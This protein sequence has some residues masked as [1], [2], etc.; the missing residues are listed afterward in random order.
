MEKTRNENGSAD[1]AVKKTAA[2]FGISPQTEREM[3]AFFM[4]TSVPRRIA[5][6]EQ[7]K[8]KPE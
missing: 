7:N 3:V 1:K 5:E 2:D 4:R 6:M 8:N